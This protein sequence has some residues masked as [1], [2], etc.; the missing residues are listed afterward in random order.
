[1]YYPQSRCPDRL[2]Q[3][4]LACQKTLEQII[5]AEDMGKIELFYFDESGFSQKSNLPSAW[6]PKGEPLTMPCYS[7]S[8]RLNVL[9]FL[10]RKGTLVYH[11]TESKVNTDVVIG[12]FEDFIGTKQLDKLTIVY[13]DDASF[14]RAKRFK[15]KCSEW[16]LKGL[17]IMYLPAYSPE[18]N[19]I[20][21]LWNKIKYE[22][23]S[24]HALLRLRR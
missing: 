22:W 12:A 3:N 2:D 16:L 1:M 17:V 23:L 19:I 15:E 20:K 10:S 9:G 6:S 21:I 4:I 13:L 5:V 18:L 11:T 8:N 14:H 24:Y 7:H